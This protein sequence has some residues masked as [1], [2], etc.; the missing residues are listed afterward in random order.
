MSGLATVVDGIATRLGTALGPTITVSDAA[1]ATA[2]EL[3]VVVLSVT[4]AQQELVGIGRIPRG[5]RTGALA[6]AIAIDLDAPVLDLGG[7][8]TL[9][10][11]SANRREVTIPHGPLVKLDGTD[12]TPFDGSDVSAN[13]GAAFAVV[14]GSPAGRQ[15]RVDPVGGIFRF[16]ANLK[17]SGTLT[18]T[19]HV[20]QWD[21]TT[22]RFQGDL[23]V[24]ILATTTPLARVTARL[25]ADA[26]AVSQSDARLTPL[27]WGEVGNVSVGPGQNPTNAHAQLLTYRF[28][29]ELEAPILPSGGGVISRIA[30]VERIRTREDPSAPPSDEESF[31]IPAG[32]V[33]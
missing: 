21:V 32:A 30:V 17:A 8:E 20:G 12:D 23:G 31:D 14:S 33:A 7:G 25:V 18:L 13:D 9:V 3:P 5:T 16:G 27:A 1:P 2:A 6:V 4:A 10:L 19:Y 22:T 24:R 15:L 11:I 28:D 29:T 26:L